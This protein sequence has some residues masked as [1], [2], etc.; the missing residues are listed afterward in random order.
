MDGG[1]SDTALSKILGKKETLDKDMI[2]LKLPK[3][4]S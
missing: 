1:Q 3:R 2:S 4:G